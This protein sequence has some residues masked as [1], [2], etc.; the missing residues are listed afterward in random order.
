MHN[1]SHV[2]LKPWHHANVHALYL[3]VRNMYL[4][5]GMLLTIDSSQFKAE[6]SHAGLETNPL[7]RRMQ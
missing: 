5:T 2:A 7:S 4:A 6:L 1:K 3:G